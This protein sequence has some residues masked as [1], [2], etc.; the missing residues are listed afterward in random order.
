M[1]ELPD[2]ES[3]RRILQRNAARHVITKVEVRDEW[4]LRGVSAHALRTQ[5]QGKRL[6]STSRHGKYL[7]AALEPKGFL[8]FHFGMTDIFKVTGITNPSGNTTALFSNSMTVSGSP[9]TAAAG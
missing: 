2:V 1:P 3:F 9:S 4:I 8:V 6:T 7:F 5:V